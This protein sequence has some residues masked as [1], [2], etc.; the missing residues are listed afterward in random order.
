MPAPRKPHNKVTGKRLFSHES[1]SKFKNYCTDALLYVLYFE[2]ISWFRFQRCVHGLSIFCERLRDTLNH[3]SGNKKLVNKN[4]KVQPVFTYQFTADFNQSISSRFS[5]YIFSCSK[6]KIKEFSK[7][8]RVKIHIFC[9]QSDGVSGKVC[10]ICTLFTN[11][12]NAV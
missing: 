5:F 10:Q 3:F 11:W 7:L 6:M 1:I 8:I 4:F 12:K 2:K 9:H